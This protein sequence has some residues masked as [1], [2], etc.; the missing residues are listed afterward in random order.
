MELEVRLNNLYQNGEINIYEDGSMTLDRPVVEFEGTLTDDYHLYKKGQ[1]LDQV[2]YMYYKDLVPDSS[3]F[4]W[5]IADANNIQNPMDMAEYAG[6]ELLVPNITK[7][8]LRLNT[9]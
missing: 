7:A 6:K 8:L 1:T 2:A 4:W 5:I 3:K 9:A